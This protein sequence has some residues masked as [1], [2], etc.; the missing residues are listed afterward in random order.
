[1]DAARTVI[2]WIG[3]LDLLVFSSIMFLVLVETVDSEDNMKFFCSLWSGQHGSRRSVTCAAK[4]L[5][6]LQTATIFV[7]KMNQLPRGSSYS[8]LMSKAS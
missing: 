7:L 2:G 6:K 4:T 8:L 5:Y 1:M 3:W